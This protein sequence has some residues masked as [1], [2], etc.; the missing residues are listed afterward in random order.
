M[1][2]E[3]FRGLLV[4][5]YRELARLSRMLAEIKRGP[6]AGGIGP[7]QPDDRESSIFIFIVFSKTDRLHTPV[8]PS[9]G[10][11]NYRHSRSTRTAAVR[12]LAK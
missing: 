1:R 4:S 12:R 8:R 10:I 5:I 2:L 9:T 11:E 7:R 3:F 6:A